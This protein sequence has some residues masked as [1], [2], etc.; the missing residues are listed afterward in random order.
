MLFLLVAQGPRHGLQT[1][2]QEIWLLESREGTGVLGR[3]LRVSE[4]SHGQ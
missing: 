4:N 2:E 3:G 1:K